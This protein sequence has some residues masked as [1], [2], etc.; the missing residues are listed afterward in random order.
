[1]KS[2]QITKQLKYG[3][4]LEFQLTEFVDLVKLT[5]S[6]DHREKKVR[7]VHVVK[8]ILIGVRNMAARKRSVVQIVRIVI[9]SLRYG[10]WFLLNMILMGKNIPFCHKRT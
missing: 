3:K 1:M 5:I 7:V 2:L 4:E 8:Y 6:G 9:D 10:I